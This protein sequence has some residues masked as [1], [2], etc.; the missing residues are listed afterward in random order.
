MFHNISYANLILRRSV[1]AI[2]G[3]GDVN[4]CALECFVFLV[5]LLVVFGCP[6][7]ASVMRA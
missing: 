2:C 3:S 4:A 5:L 6:T 1:V 7:C